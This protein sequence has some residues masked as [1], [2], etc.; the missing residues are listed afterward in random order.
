MTA[1]DLHRIEQLPVPPARAAALARALVLTARPFHWFNTICMAIFAV[2][3]TRASADFDAALALRRTLT[4]V[5]LLFLLFF[6]ND[7]MHKRDDIRMER[8]RLFQLFALTR[9]RVVA[10]LTSLTFAVVASSDDLSWRP[11]ALIFAIFAAGMFYGA[12]K[13]QRRPLATY[14]ARALAGAAMFVYAADGPAFGGL[15]LV[16]AGFVGLWDLQAHIAGDLRDLPMDKIAGVRTLPSAWGEARTLVA[17]ALCQ[18]AALVVLEAY[19][20][21]VG[22]AL[23]PATLLACGLLMLT[24]WAAYAWLSAA[25]PRTRF[26]WL[27][28][29]F[30]GPKALFYLVVAG[31]LMAWNWPERAALVL[32]GAVVWFCSYWIYLWSDFRLGKGGGPAARSPKPIQKAP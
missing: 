6:C 13:F 5:L 28:A 22:I 2:A 8:G 18:G 9:G 21:L 10:I 12:A 31:E 23:S 24:G 11:L 20:R 15:Q 17:I 14:A 29:C 26:A 3:L 25:R 4:I 1:H 32:G 19:L 27:H 7:F 16:A 30:H